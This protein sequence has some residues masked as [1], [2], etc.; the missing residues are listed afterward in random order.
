MPDSTF[1]A[2]RRRFSARAGS[3]QQTFPQRT[4][5]RPEPETRNGLSLAR[6]DAFAT[7]TRSTFL[8]CPFESTYKLCADPLDQ[9]LSARFGFEA[10]TGRIHHLRPVIHA[11][12]IRSHDATPSPLPFRRFGP[13]DQSVQRASS[14]EARLTGHPIC[15]SLPA[16]LSF[17]CASDQCS[18]LRFALLGYR[19][20]NPGT[21]S[22]MHP[23]P[24]SGQTKRAGFPQLLRAIFSAGY[25]RV[26][27]IPCA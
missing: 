21:E 4:C 5:I 26:R 11:S 14:Q 22:I 1:A 6:N 19:S 25:G 9:R 18:K 20:V 12:L 16:A 23:A 7:I 2:R 13:P 10:V 17:D 8:A 3:V 15:I 24:G 27:W